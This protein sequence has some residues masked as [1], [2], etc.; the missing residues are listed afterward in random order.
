MRACALIASRFH[1][2]LVVHTDQCAPIPIPIP[3]TITITI[4]I[5]ITITTPSHFGPLVAQHPPTHERTR[6]FT[7]ALFDAESERRCT[8]WAH[9]AA[10]G[11][12]YSVA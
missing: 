4:T 3:I 6:R 9:S 7:S 11:G 1:D 12:G 10:T 2:R 8:L 5:A